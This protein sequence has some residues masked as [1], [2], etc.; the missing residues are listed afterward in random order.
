MPYYPMIPSSL[1]PILREYRKAVT[2]TEDAAAAAKAALAL[3]E[4]TSAEYAALIASGAEDKGDTYAKCEAAYDRF[5]RERKRSKRASALACEKAEEV[6]DLL[7]DSK[8]QLSKIAH[9]LEADADK[10][11][12]RYFR[13]DDLR[14]QVSKKSD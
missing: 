2:I 6:I 9:E 1:Q 11:N 7:G 3:V 5:C 10:A 4:T 14:D 8:D 13:T 12:T